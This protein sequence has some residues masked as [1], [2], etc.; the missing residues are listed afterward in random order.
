MEWTTGVIINTS[1]AIF[2]ILWGA[3]ERISAISKGKRHA[4]A[5]DRDRNSLLIFYA[6]IFFGY[7]VGIPVAFTGYG[8]ITVFFPYLS[9]IGIAIVF[10]GL[11]IRLAAIRS[12]A[13]HFTYTVK[14]VDDHR[15]VTSG[16][17]RHVRHP[18][19]LGQA[20]IFLGCGVAFSNWISILALCIP[21][22]V[23]AYY[24]IA[25]EEKVLLE[26]FGE[27]YRE[28]MGRTKRLVPWV[29]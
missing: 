5:G 1:T 26:H 13:E 7:G 21:T 19:Y 8:R 12:L 25:V 11:M 2:M 6:T 16:I 22:L 14:I 9:F 17:Y 24:R 10:A 15:L 3:Y 4:A 18:A 23:A 27:N 29:Y 20:M 28:Y